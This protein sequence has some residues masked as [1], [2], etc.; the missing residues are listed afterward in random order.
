MTGLIVNEIGTISQL[1][2]E[3]KYILNLTYTKIF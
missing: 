1:F 2:E 3:K